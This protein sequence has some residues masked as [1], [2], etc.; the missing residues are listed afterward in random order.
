MLF[1]YCEFREKKHFR[2]HGGV[3]LNRPVAGVTQENVLY[4]EEWHL[5]QAGALL[6]MKHKQSGATYVVPTVDIKI[7]LVKEEDA[8]PVAPSGRGNAP[9]GA[10]G[11]RSSTVSG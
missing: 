9:G 4:E 11:G 6:I 10:R 5:E 2:P 7:A 1:R 3:G 8:T